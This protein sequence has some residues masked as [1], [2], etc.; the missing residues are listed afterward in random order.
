MFTKVAKFVHKIC[1]FSDRCLVFHLSTPPLSC[2]DAAFPA[3]HR[4]FPRAKSPRTNRT[5]ALDAEQL[6]FSVTTVTP[7][8][9]SP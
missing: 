7:F 4:P 9:P 2:P 6:Y 1:D 3:K 5:R 8:S